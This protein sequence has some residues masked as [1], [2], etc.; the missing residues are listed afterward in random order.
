MLEKLKYSRR[1]ATAEDA[2]KLEPLLVEG[3][4]IKTPR[5]WYSAVCKI[6]HLMMAIHEDIK[7]VC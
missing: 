3:C 6:K 5:K 7:E 4:I 2:S 1:P